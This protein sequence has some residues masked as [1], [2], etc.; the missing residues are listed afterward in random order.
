M[1]SFNNEINKLILEDKLK[2][3]QI[4]K[5]DRDALFVRMMTG[6]QFDLDLQRK[7]LEEKKAK[8]DAYYTEQLSREGLTTDQI[9]DLND[10]KLS[11]QITY[12][13]KSN[14]IERSRISVKQKALDDIIS[15]AGAESDV[16]RAALVAK[17]ILM[18]KELVMEIKRTIT[19]STQAAARSTVAVA[20]GTAQTAKVGF[21]Q[22]IPL[23]IGYAAQAA[24]II[25]SI[26]SAVRSAKSAASS[27]DTGSADTGGGQNLGR[28]YEEG[29]LIGGKR[30]AQGGTMIEAEAGEAIMTRGAV[31]MFQP[32]LS[33]MNQMGGGTA[34]GNQ[35]F[36]KYD[37]PAVNNPQ[38]EQSP[39]IMKTYVVS[40]ELTSEQEKLAR[41]KDLSTL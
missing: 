20:E 34:F 2:K 26:V 7:L 31:T 29:G 14:E 39:V 41:L 27:G 1:T 24:A 4:E 30:H 16:G 10:R 11:D 28:N 8:D 17:Q 37:A 18:A 6:A 3:E 15:I 12:T 5:G 35:L 25:S 22:N 19:F 38:Q 23:L 13:E 9:R 36:T 33:M 40:N 32:M 21:P